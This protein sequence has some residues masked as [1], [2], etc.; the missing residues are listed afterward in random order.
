MRRIRQWQGRPPLPLRVATH[1]VHGLTSPQKVNN[2]LRSWAACPPAQHPH[3]LCLQETWLNTPDQPSQ[4]EAAAWIHSACTDPA[5]AGLELAPPTCL[6]ASNMQDGGAHY[7]GV[8]VIQLRALP[9]LSIHL[10]PSGAHPS[11]RLLHGIV[12][13]GSHRLSPSPAHTGQSDTVPSG[14]T[15]TRCSAHTCPTASEPACCL[16]VTSTTSE[17]TDAEAARCRG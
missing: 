4:H 1:N 13:W 12:V 16:S 15:G 5:L 3:I 17:V 10:A 2:L 7:A 8:A 6:F 14:T 11:G 9:E